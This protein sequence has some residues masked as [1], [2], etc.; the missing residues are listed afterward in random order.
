MKKTQFT[1][2]GRNIKKTAVSFFSIF[3]FILFSVTLFLGLTWGSEAIYLSANEDFQQSA[4]HD[5]EIIFPYGATS[6]EIARFKEIEGISQAE[7]CYRTYQRFFNGNSIYQA[8]ISSLTHNIN[9]INQIEGKLPTE[10]NE[11]LVEKAWAKSHD[12]KIGDYMVFYIDD[13]GVDVHAMQKLMSGDITSF[14]EVTENEDG[15]KYLNSDTFIVCGLGECPTLITTDASALG[16]APTNNVPIN[17][18]M[19]VDESAFD[20]EAFLGYSYVFLRSDELN[21]DAFY[22]EQYKSHLRLLKE[23]IEPLAENMSRE[24]MQAIQAACAPYAAMIGEESIIPELYATVLDR[25]QSSSIALLTISS[26]S[27]GNLKY[28]LSISLLVIALLIC[29]SVVSRTIFEQSVQIGT[30]KALG[31]SSREIILSYFCYSGL[32]SIGGSLLGIVIGR[33]ILEPVIV[34]QIKN[35]FTFASNVYTFSILEPVALFLI[36]LA[37]VLLV[38]YFSCKKVLKQDTLSLLNKSGEASVKHRFYE[39]WKVWKKLP[40]LTKTIVNN[41]FNDKKRVIGTIIGVVGVMTLMTC[42]LTFSLN[43]AKS[44]DV[45]F[46]RYQDFEYIIYYDSK[47]ETEEKIIQLLDG[48]QVSYCKALVTS[49]QIELNDDSSFLTTVFVPEKAEEFNKLL[50]L[51]TPEGKVGSVE[52]GVWICNSIAANNALKSGDKVTYIDNIRGKVTDIP[53]ANINE[54]YLMAPS[55]YLTQEKYKELFQIEE[56]LA[57]NVILVDPSGYDLESNFFSFYNINGVLMCANYKDDALVNFYG[58]SSAFVLMST[59][60]LF[61]AVMMALLVILNLMI[62]FV[63][64]KKRDLITLMINGY[65][66]AKTKQYIYSDTILLTVIGILLGAVSGT[67]LGKLATRAICCDF[68]YFFFDVNWVA[69]LASAAVTAALVAFIT[70]VSLR[71]I[72]GFKLTEVS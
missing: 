32:A 4:F 37:F 16:M 1:E 53:V 40:L 23:K 9:L 44:C 12:V 3:A 28:C 58:M 43:V 36:C 68:F 15:M 35:V 61:M 22:T 33:L 69:I 49:G 54:Y 34:A 71:R 10:S 7:G 42:G 50:K 6:E 13:D 14:M 18:T 21:R 64:E 25:T 8:S 57:S 19:F 67:F 70:F 24:T 20:R 66:I 51:T 31:F 52:D 48:F 59:V 56:K 72:K 29:Y 45:Y 2:L 38:T 30:K 65:S 62:T 41:F 60:F 5:F 39:R 26:E 17:C 47:E 63:Q 55:V 27:T 11:I 46:D